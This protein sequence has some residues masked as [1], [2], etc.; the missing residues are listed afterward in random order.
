MSR[1]TEASSEVNTQSG[2]HLNYKRVLPSCKLMNWRRASTK[3]SC[4]QFQPNVTSQVDARIPP[5]RLPG[6]WR[7]KSRT[8]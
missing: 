6:G 4:A 1:N 3:I 2:G 7:W 5:E 8:G